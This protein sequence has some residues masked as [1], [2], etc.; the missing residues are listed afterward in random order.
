MAEFV[1]LEGFQ[2]KTLATIKTELETSFKSIFGNDI[3]LD[4]T[5]PIGQLIGVLSQ[6]MADL[7]DGA[8]EIYTSRNP[9][10]A[11]GLSLDNISGETGIR[12]IDSTKTKAENVLLDGDEGTIIAVGK[13]TKQANNALL[14]SLLTAVTITKAA[15]LKLKL[16]PNSS[17][18]LAGGEVFTVTL[19]AVPYTY[20]G[21]ASDTIDVVI[22]A[23]VSTITG[24]AFTGTVSNENDEFLVIN[25]EDSDSDTIP[26]TAFSAVWT[27]TFDLE[28]LASGG[29]F[30]ADEFG[31]NAL[32]ATTLDT[33]AT[34]VTGWDGVTNPKAG[35]TGREV[36]TDDALR[37]RRALTFL[38]GNATEEAI[39]SA[40]LNEVSGVVSVSVSSNRTL[41][42]DGSGLP[43]KSFEVVVEGGTDADL[44]Q[45]I[46][47]TMPAGIESFGSTS[48]II[49]DSQGNN[50]TINFSRPETMFVWIKVKR[51]FNTEEPYPTDGD[52]QIK[53]SIVAYGL[54]NL[55]PGTDL[56]RQRL[57]EPVYAV[58]G[59]GDI[60]ITLDFST[61]GGHSPV[62]SEQNVVV[63]ARQ[64]I[65][66]D[67]TRIIVE[68]L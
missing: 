59:I 44:A 42:V 40:V 48:E 29:T 58:P 20:N 47:E 21:I 64:L 63:T 37:I 22:D 45:E 18:P 46:W 15:A 41:V 10:E 34:P 35:V 53:N 16:E 4:P 67:V 65:D 61:N 8:N 27:G 23:L 12:R 26:D 7:W 32:P 9:S 31:A 55:D 60:E 14:Y 51:S 13:Q 2:K 68:A 56:I 25:G 19:D 3:D 30:E 57:S 33:I 52:T 1:T 43:P 54:I 11:T 5:G 24:G 28:L 66:L 62:Y 38:A 17:F 49:I 50:Q 39:R 6:E 36:E